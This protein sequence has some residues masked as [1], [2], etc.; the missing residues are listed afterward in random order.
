MHQFLEMIN[1]WQYSLGQSVGGMLET[2][3]PMVILVVFAAGVLTSLTP[4]VYPM[5]PVTVAYMG[6]AAAGS[7]R[8]AVWLSAVYV[9]GMAVVYTVLG[10][11]V[12]MLG[13]TFGQFTR[14]AWVFAP[15]GLL[16]LLF[17]VA[18]LDLISIPVPGFAGKV[19]AKG[20]QRG[21]A[22]G[23]LLM[24]FAAGFVAAPCTA[25]VLLTL[26]THVARTRDVVWGGTLMFVFSL[27][28]GV[29]L[30]IVGIFSGIMGTL[31]KPGTWMVI[32]KKSFGILMLAVGVWF[33]YQAYFIL[34]HPVGGG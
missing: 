1:E 5:I 3:S 20:A 17:G 2:N 9:L 31:P 7:R 6:A 34:M 23:A 29:L 11:V 8:R 13:K 30:M 19:Q 4:C 22:L 21:G 27:G 12:A 25:P 18:M 24:G 26:L 33:L 16:M 15:V 32:V 28:L 14:S 10:V